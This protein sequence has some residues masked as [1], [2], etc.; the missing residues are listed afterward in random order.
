[1]VTSVCSPICK[2]GLSHPNKDEQS[3]KEPQAA[4]KSQGDRWKQEPFIKAAFCFELIGIEL[5]LGFTTES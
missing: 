5:P 1:M 3:N 4:H 2:L